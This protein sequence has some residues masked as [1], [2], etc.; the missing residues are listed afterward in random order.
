MSEEARRAAF[1]A[2]LVAIAVAA[3]II[4]V[5]LLLPLKVAAQIPE[6]AGKWKHT[7]TRQARLEWGID[8]E[9]CAAAGSVLYPEGS[10]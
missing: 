10:S 2:R 1:V 6:A 4:C 9:D 3:L 7:L 5:A 8:V